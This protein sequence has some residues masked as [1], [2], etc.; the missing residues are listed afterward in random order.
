MP[1]PFNTV[2]PLINNG[3]G[4]F[5]A[6]GTVSVGNAPRSAQIADFND[7]GVRDAVVMSSGDDTAAWL[8]SAPQAGSAGLDFG[9]L[10]TGTTSATLP[11]TFTNTGEAP[12]NVG[13]AAL[14]VTAGPFAPAIGN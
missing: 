2:Q 7:D 9:Q 8:F 14:S 4:T 6:L 11:V 13:S 5:G 10:A 12:L 3:T 1:L